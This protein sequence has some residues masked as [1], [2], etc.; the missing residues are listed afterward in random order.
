[1]NR[2]IL[3]VVVA[4]CSGAYAQTPRTSSIGHPIHRE[5]ARAWLQSFE[6][7]NP[8]AVLGHMYGKQALQELL[9]LEGVAGLHISKGWDDTGTER[10]I[11]QAAS[12]DGAVI[13]P[14]LVYDRARSDHCTPDLDCEEPGIATI[15]GR[16]DGA[17]AQRW[18]TRFQD[19]APNAVR[20][21]LFGRKVFEELL[22]QEGAEGIYLAYGLDGAGSEHLVLVGVDGKGRVM[23]DGPIINQ[24]QLCPPLCAN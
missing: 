22:A 12:E 14:E 16:V 2:L 15:G 23:W 17:L 5:T 21:H 20:S 18:M 10:L 4:L 11:F 8:G 1:M 19:R 6:H 9:A 24:G 3:S 7:K 13:H